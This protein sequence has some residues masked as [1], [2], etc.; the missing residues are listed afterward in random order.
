MVTFEATPMTQDANQ[1]RQAPPVWPAAALRTGNRPRSS[2]ATPV[3]GFATIVRESFL[4]SLPRGG[5][6]QHVVRWKGPW[7]ARSRIKHVGGSVLL[8]TA[9]PLV[10]HETT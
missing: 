7:L 1:L 4:A 5:N 3:A 8:H 2:G 6:C 10:C 9:N